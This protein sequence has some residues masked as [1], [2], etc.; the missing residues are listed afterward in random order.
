MLDDFFVRALIAGI[1][2][3]LIAG[4]LGCFIVWRRLAY[5]GD[6]LA[7]AALL[8]VALAFLLE[9][10]ITATVFF[11]SASVAILLLLLQKKASLSSD[12]LL[13]LLSHSSLALGLVV[14]AFMGS[15]RFDLMGLL[16][17]DILS[18]SKGDIALIYGGG[19][20]VLLVLA[21]VWRRLFAATVSPELAEAEGM[22]PDIANIVFMLLMAMVI[23]IAMKIVGVLL[24]TAL[25]IVPAAT[26]RRFAAGPEQMAVLSALIGAVAVIGGLSGSLR[27]DTPSGPSIVVAAS[28]LFILSLSSGIRRFTNRSET[29]EGPLK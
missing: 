13:G 7:H 9:V 25:L 24:I 2:V 18:V 19:L 11:V 6:T 26:A 5:F 4:P 22:R 28:L 14:L 3:A 27:W 29:R 15:V 23:A 21:A 17:G 12:A 16:F 10:N 20:A 1:G 8:G